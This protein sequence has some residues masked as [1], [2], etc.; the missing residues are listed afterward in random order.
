MA[1][2]T[3]SPT[4][5][6]WLVALSF[7]ASSIFVHFAVTRPTPLLERAAL[8]A[9]AFVPFSVGM[10]ELRFGAWCAFALLAATAWWLVGL[11]GGAPFLFLPSILIPALLTWFFASTLRPGR[12]SLITAVARAARPDTPDYL[13]RYSRTLTVLWASLFAAMALWD[14]LL[15]AFAPQRWWSFM[16]NLANYL[17]V[18]AFVVGEYVFRRLRFRDYAH[19]GFVEYVMLVAKTNPRRLRG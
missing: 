2:V 10:A 16:A 19:P 11:D 12:E 1:R 7:A 8:I 3:L 17:V 18:G 4:T 13:L 9:L 15:A 6:A 5:R 14:G